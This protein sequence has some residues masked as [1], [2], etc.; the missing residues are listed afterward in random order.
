MNTRM[1]ITAEF[2]SEGHPD[3][4]C[5]QV[6]DRILDKALEL[7]NSSEKQLIRTAIEC[8]VKDNLLIVSGE[9]NIP[10]HI[11]AKLDVTSLAHQVWKDV[12]YGD[13]KEMLTVINHIREQSPEIAGSDGKG[14][15]F[16]GAGDQ[17]IMVGYATDETE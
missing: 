11:Y 2:V 6:A 9:V 1:P 5:D 7:S 17:G 4:F 15:N 14:T 12:G 16:G 3:K 10:P 8:L 13:N